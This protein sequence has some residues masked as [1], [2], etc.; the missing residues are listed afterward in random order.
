[1]FETCIFEPCPFTINFFALMRETKNRQQRSK[2]LGM[3]SIMNERMRREAIE[4][5][6]TQM[7]ELMERT[8]PDF[9]V[10]ERMWK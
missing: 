5:N 4:S 2:Y 10:E 7:K 1:M 3:V 8:T 6:N 9:Y